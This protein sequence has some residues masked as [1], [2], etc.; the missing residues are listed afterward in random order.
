M[1]MHR[2][3]GMALLVML[4]LLTVMSIL[5]SQM[6]QSYRLVWQKSINSQVAQQQRWY[7]LGGESFI[8]RVLS[9]SA[10]DEL[11]KTTLAQYWAIQGRVFPVE[12][13][14]MN[15]EVSDAQACFNINSLLTYEDPGEK[16]LAAP[17]FYAEQVFFHLLRG[18]E[19]D[20]Y[21]AQQV[22]A[23]VEDWLDANTAPR[24]NGSEDNDY[25][26]LTPPYL[27]ANQA[28]QDISEL[29]MVK[30]VDAALYRRL[31][32]YLCALP[33]T[34]LQININTLGTQQAPLLSALFVNTLSMQE[35]GRI[36]AQRPRDGW[37]SVAQFLQ[38]DA[39]LNI[40]ATDAGASVDSVLSVKSAYFEARL[41]VQT[42]NQKTSMKSLFHRQ[43][44]NQMR[45]IRRHYGETW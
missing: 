5:A 8:G 21:R 34:T 35:A 7:L 38:Q 42:A 18:L 17:P 1:K 44:D 9:Q 31:V 29:R 45:V 27:P 23:A 28:M 32:P 24:Q 14:R 22:T 25:L 41:Q 16:Q 15:G 3:Q 26:A 13:S 4:L 11:G 33:E 19:L 39:L 37:D 6:T 36:I 2:Q 43:S 10:R 12:D 30:G 20:E 40:A